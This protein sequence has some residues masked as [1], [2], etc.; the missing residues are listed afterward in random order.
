MRRGGAVRPAPQHEPKMATDMYICIQTY[1]HIDI[2]TYTYR[3]IHIYIYTYIHIDIY[4]YI[5]IYIQ[6]Y[7][8]IYLYIHIYTYLYL[9]ICILYILCCMWL[10]IIFLLANISMHQCIDRPDRIHSS[11]NIILH[12]AVKDSLQFIIW[13]TYP[14]IIFDQTYV[15]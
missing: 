13:G 4:I 2:Y 15:R 10:Q 7:T 8:Y 6:T 1:R 3:H 14:Q 11:V 9:C 5:Y 12:L